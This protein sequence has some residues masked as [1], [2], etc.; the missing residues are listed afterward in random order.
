MDTA[1]TFLG[2][3]GQPLIYA[4]TFTS[5]I[6]FL[7][8]GYDLGFMGGLTTSTKF[9]SV[10]GNPNSALLGFIVA[11]Y[12]VGALFGAL[13]QFVMGDRFGRKTNTLAGAVVVA[14]GAILQASTTE[15]GQ[16]LVGRIVGG[17]GLGCMTTCIPIWLTEC[18]NRTN[19]GRMMAMQLSNLIVGLILSNWLD[20]G[21]QDYSSSFS[22]RFPCA[23]QIIFCI[24]VCIVMPFLPESPRYLFRSGQIERGTTSLAALRGTTREDESVQLEIKEI[25]YILD[26]EAEED[27]S[28]A[29]CFKDGGIYGWQRVLVAFSANFFQQLSGVNVM[30]SLGPYV[31][32]NSIGMSARDA[33]LVSGGLQVFYFLSSLIPWYTTNNVGRR[34]LFMI[35]SAGMGVCMLLSAIFV[36]VGTKGLGYAAAVVLYLFQ[37]FFTLG[38]QSNMWI[39]PS[40]ILP[41]KLRLRGGALAVVSQWLFT[42]VVVQITPP[43][44][45]NIKFRSY[46]VFAVVNFFTIPCIY[47]FY[48]ETL[49]LPLEAVDLLFTGRPGEARPS[50]MQAVRNSTK[51]EFKDQIM[52]T[53]IERAD[54]EGGDTGIKLGPVHQ[55]TAKI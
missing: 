15:L 42:F 41:L 11:S 47:F 8:F 30:S 40:E 49:R 6:G 1:P 48:P 55:E 34:K 39:Y 14:I 23:F 13:F 54:H 31:F 45:T 20:Y 7:L 19:R 2:L 46:I 22:W 53:L 43:M 51:K 28:W 32:Q 5:S 33:L 10:F 17:F 36:G 18:A 9:L 29:D 25:Q 12:E 26:V 27:G 35:G 44:I 50:Y 38:W 3:R 52:A 4:V 21:T 37:T 16:F 24:I